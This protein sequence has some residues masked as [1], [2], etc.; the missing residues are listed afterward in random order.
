MTTRAQRQAE[1]PTEQ[2]IEADTALCWPAA[3]TA[4]PAMVK[5]YDEYRGDDLTD[6]TDDQ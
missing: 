4:D 5:Q 3:A 1:K 6:R 2:Y